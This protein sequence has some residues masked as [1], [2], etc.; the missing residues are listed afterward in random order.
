MAFNHSF[1]NRQKQS[2]DIA[3]TVFWYIIGHFTV[4]QGSGNHIPLSKHA[5]GSEGGRSG[6]LRYGMAL[7][8]GKVMS[9]V[10]RARG[11]F[12]NFHESVDFVSV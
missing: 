2:W 7:T 12:P 3:E 9:L 6:A 1:T 10:P 11:Q 5:E 8:K 4:L